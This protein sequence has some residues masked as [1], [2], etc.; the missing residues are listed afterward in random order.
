MTTLFCFAINA[1]AVA[2]NAALYANDPN[3]VSLGCI[4]F[5]G[6]FAAFFLVM[7]VTE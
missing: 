4:V 1:A 7:A 6:L 5:S 3:P 2:V